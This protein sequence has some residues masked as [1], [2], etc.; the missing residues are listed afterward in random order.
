MSR[1]TILVDAD[2]TLWENAVYFEDARRLYLD[3][4]VSF[5]CDRD[6]SQS[7]LERIDGR[8]I[9]AG[10][11]GSR[12][13][14]A[15][16]LEAGRSAVDGREHDRL[17]AAIEAIGRSVIEHPI[18]LHRCVVPA[19]ARLRRTSDL[20]VVTMGDAAEQCGK[21]ERSRLGPYFKGIEV[22]ADKTPDAYRDL[23]ARRGLDARVTWM[24]GNSIA[25]DIA[26]AQALGI[27]TAWVRTVDPAHVSRGLPRATP[28]LIVDDL[29]AFAA[30]LLG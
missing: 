25:K 26:P 20:L 23:L 29:G 4:L 17:T 8:H 30:F 14:V 2:D 27:R 7:E 15:S 10:W 5:G 28:D 3:L 9:A 13:L 24:V 16:M 18:R 6:R 21:I 11:F 19:L 12:R 1:L 22:L